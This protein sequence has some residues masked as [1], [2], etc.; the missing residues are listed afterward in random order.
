MQETTSSNNHMKKNSSNF[1]LQM[2]NAHPGLPG[3]HH[4]PTSWNPYQINGLFVTADFD[5]RVTNLPF[6]NMDLMCGFGPDNVGIAA[7]PGATC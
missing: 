1:T 5:L 3:M 7:W 2:Y 4:R 6:G